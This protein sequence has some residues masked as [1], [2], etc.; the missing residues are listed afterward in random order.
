VYIVEN[1]PL[2]VRFIEFAKEGGRI[3]YGDAKEVKDA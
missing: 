3:V 1:K 2:P